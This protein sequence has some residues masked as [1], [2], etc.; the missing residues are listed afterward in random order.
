[1]LEWEGAY[2]PAV[3]IEIGHR[4]ATLCNIGDI[5]YRLGRTLRWD[6]EKEEFTGDPQANCL[7]RAPQRHPHHL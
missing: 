2:R 5:A 7:L 1:M 4:A 3:D 6:G